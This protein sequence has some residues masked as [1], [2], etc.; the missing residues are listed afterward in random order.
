MKI[1]RVLVVVCLAGTLAAAQERTRR[2]Y[3]TALDDNDG[4]VTDLTA[5]DVTVKESG[6][7]RPIQRLEP[8]RDTMSI[9]ILVDDNGTGMFRVGV[10]RFIEALL[11]RAEFAISVVRGQTVKLVDYTADTRQLS[12]A[13]AQLGAHPS[14]NDGNQLLDGIT[15]ASL[16]MVKHKAVR[17]VIVAL[18]VGGDD[19]TPMQ[20][21]D[22]LDDLR[23]SGAQLYVVSVLSSAF[24][25]TV[26]TN[27]PADLLNEGHALKAMLGD[28]PQRSG[29]HREDISA[30]AGVDPRLQQLAAQLKQQYVL[31]YALE[32][33]K[34]SK[35][36]EVNGKRKNVTVRAATYVPDKMF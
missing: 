32:G 9:A 23:K 25:A 21:E 16:A 13:V 34:P 7:L 26:P 31:E 35:R 2:L 4:V 30:I 17:P 10:G 8:T 27:R 24:R 29:G 28:G 3:L 6:R 11:G 5:D 22:A 36:V 20:P 33:S 12:E 19:V 1:L 14:T 15:G 18:T